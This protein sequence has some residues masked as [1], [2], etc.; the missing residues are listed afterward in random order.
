VRRLLWLLCLATSRPDYGCRARYRRRLMSRMVQQRRLQRRTVRRLLWLLRAAAA[1]GRPQNIRAGLGVPSLVRDSV[2]LRH[3]VLQ[4][5]PRLRPAAASATAEATA[6]AAAAAA[7]ATVAAAAPTAALA[8]SARAAAAAT[9]PV[10]ATIAAAAS[11]ARAVCVAP[12]C[13]RLRGESFSALPNAAAA[14]L[15]A[16]APPSLGGGDP[17]RRGAEC[18]R[19]CRPRCRVRGAAAPP[20]RII[21]AARSRRRRRGEAQGRLVAGAA[22]PRVQAGWGRPLASGGREPERRAGLRGQ[23]EG[24]QGQP[25]GRVQVLQGAQ[26]EG[27][28]EQEAAHGGSG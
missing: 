14:A 10:A 27:R 24:A 8:L 20:A 15:A 28:A 19:G 12:I 2:V 21:H 11:C 7:A 5:V 16:A 22:G 6:E 23:R 17:T 18:G 25:I 26:Q 13:L 9:S 3:A 1:R 4:R